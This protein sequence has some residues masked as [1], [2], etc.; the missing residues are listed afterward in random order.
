MENQGKGYSS[1]ISCEVLDIDG[2]SAREESQSRSKLEFED[3][4]DL[5]NVNVPNEDEDESEQDLHNSVDETGAI[6][7]V[8]SNISDEAIPKIDMKFLT[9]EAAYQFYNTY[10]Y[11][12]GFS[13]RRSKEYKDASGQSNNNNNNKV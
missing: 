10:A 2:N 11:K 9:E 6:N 13:V 4:D 1:R 7:L 5:F 12:V 8:H 3:R